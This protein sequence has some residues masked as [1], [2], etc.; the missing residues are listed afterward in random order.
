MFGLTLCHTSACATAGYYTNGIPCNRPAQ[1]LSGAHFTVSVA[2]VTNDTYFPFHPCDNDY[3]R[4]GSPLIHVVT[5]TFSPLTG[6]VAAAMLLA[7]TTQCHI[8]VQARTRTH[9]FTQ[10]ATFSP[11]TGVVASAMLVGSVRSPYCV[12]LC[13]SAS[14]HIVELSSVACRSVLLCSPVPPYACCRARPL[15]TSA[16]ATP[17]N[18]LLRSIA[19]SRLFPAI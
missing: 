2:P 13:M 7:C 11:L 6:M 18:H 12:R 3:W 9:T 1:R 4:V 16:T 15:W 17:C 10:G 14:S 8:G 19:S 5:G